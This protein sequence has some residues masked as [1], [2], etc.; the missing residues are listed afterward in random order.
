MTHIK[1]QVMNKVRTVYFLRRTLAPFIFLVGAAVVIAS[2]VSVSN[3]ISNMPVVSDIS[4]LTK[5]FV[6]AIAHTDVVVKSA[7]VAGLIMLLLVLKG[8]IEGIR[9]SS[10]QAEI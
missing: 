5:F 4:A 10:V 3:V 8:L 9:F 2:T 7:L 1:V 6:A